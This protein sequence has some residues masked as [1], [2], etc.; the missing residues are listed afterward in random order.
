MSRHSEVTG[1]RF[2]KL[3]SQ[4]LPPQGNYLGNIPRGDVLEDNCLSD[5][6]GTSPASAIRLPF[7]TTYFKGQPL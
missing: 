4:Q 3:F 2:A 5:R 6:F 1:R 7:Q